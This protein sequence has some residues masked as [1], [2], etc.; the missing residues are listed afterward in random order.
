MKGKGKRT[1]ADDIPPATPA[2]MVDEVNHLRDLQ[3]HLLC[4]IHSK[5]GIKTYCY[6]EVAGEGVEGGHR[7]FSHSDLGL[8]AEYIV[9]Q[10]R[11]NVTNKNLPRFRHV[12]WRPRLAHQILKRLTTH[13]RKNPKRCGLGQSSTLQ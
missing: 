1:R 13:R 2:K 3:V 10:T 6:I 8:W 7:E 9:S 4:A 5:H 12:A 11:M